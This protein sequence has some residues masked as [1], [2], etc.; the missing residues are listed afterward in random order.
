MQDPLNLSEQYLILPQALGPALMLCDG[1]HDAQAIA[2][3]MVTDFG[4]R[5]EL[6]M[7][8]SLVEALD[9][10]LF[11]ENERSAAGMAAGAAGLSG[12]TLPRTADR[13]QWLSRRS[14][15]IA[16]VLRRLPARGG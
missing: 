9:Q 11:L 15:R 13:R 7:V 16:G 14:R 10:S 5:I 12:R 8:E 4:I 2:V 1:E 6:D 3:A